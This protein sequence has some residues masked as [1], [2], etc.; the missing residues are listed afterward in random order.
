MRMHADEV[1]TD[2]SLVRRLLESQFPKWAEL[3]IEIVDSWGTDN[4]L[5]R[6]GGDLVARLP[7]TP[8][9]EEALA[10]EST[11]LPR[12]APLLPLAVPTRVAEGT[13]GEGYPFEWSLYRWLPGE[14]ATR[15]V[16]IDTLATARQLAAFVAALQAIDPAGGPAPG[17]HNVFRGEPLAERDEQ[18]RAAIDALRDAIDVDAVTA[19][20]ESALE[21]HE[22]EGA[23]VWIHGDLDARN[24]LVEEGRLTAVIDWGCLGVGDPAC[25]VMVGWKVLTAESRTVF[26]D[27]LPVDESTQARA[28]GWAV[29]QAVRALSYYTLE[30]NPALVHESRRWLAEV[31]AD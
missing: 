28:R 18:T 26:L 24:L 30:T 31:L 12:L 13:P 9:T 8:R 4:A 2:P 7:R 29:S 11:W 20:W 27:A 3:P 21:A 17:D 1:A 19:T 16:L 15:G 14:D 10:K 25:D 6:L 22:W 23:P 5:Y